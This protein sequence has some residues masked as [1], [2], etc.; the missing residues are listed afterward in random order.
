M[1][2]ECIYTFPSN[3]INE[4]MLGKYLNQSGFTCGTTSTNA[5]SVQAQARVVWRSANSIK[6]S[7][8]F[9]STL[10]YSGDNS[11]FSSCF[12]MSAALLRYFRYFCLAV[13]DISWEA[14]VVAVA[15]GAPD[16][17]WL[18]LHPVPMLLPSRC[19]FWPPCMST[20]AQQVTLR[21]K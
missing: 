14:P 16:G 13:T 17:A 11:W 5:W 21:H 8:R 19:T 2:P 10:R 3:I 20:S 4:R 12:L 15:A 6:A 7:I 9:V 18:G 1:T